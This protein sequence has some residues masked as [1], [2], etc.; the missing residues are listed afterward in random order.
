MGNPY[1]S[2]GVA[3]FHIIIGH[4][5]LLCRPYGDSA[6]LG[7]WV[8]SFYLS[9]VTGRMDQCMEFREWPSR[10][11]RVPLQQKGWKTLQ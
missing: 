4:L 7:K 3:K 2:Y 11:F 5:C 10:L 1:Q 8:Y 6:V 9:Y